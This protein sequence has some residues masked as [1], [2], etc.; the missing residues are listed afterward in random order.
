MSL[1]TREFSLMLDDLRPMPII[2]TI[3]IYNKR[4]ESK[5]IP[6]YLNMCIHINRD[7]SSLCDE[8]FYSDSNTSPEDKLKM[9]KKLM[10]ILDD[11]KREF[12]KPQKFNPLTDF[13]ENFVLRHYNYQEKSSPIY[14]LYETVKDHILNERYLNEVY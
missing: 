6:E 2:K 11:I 10:S 4:S 1:N 7:I 8:L 12:L 13:I 14:I 9:Y 3:M 5:L